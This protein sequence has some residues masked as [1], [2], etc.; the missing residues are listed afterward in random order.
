MPRIPFSDMKAEFKRVLLKKGTPEESAELSARLIAETSCDG[1]YSHG[2]NRFPRVVEYI[3]R[4][5]IDVSARPTLVESLGAFERWDGNLGL[6]NVCATLMMDRAIGL[7]RA[8]GIGCVA[9]AN[10]NH[11]LRGGTYGWQAANAGC[12]GLCWTNTQPNMPAWGAKDRRIGNNP[13]ILAVPRAGGAVVVD[14]AMAQFSYGQLE[15]TRN[16]GEALPVAGGYDGD[17]NLTTDPGA[18]LQS[19]RVLPIGFWKGSSLSLVLDLVATVLSGGRSTYR[20]GQLGSDEYQLSQV[21]IAIDA[22]RI[23]GDAFLA[24]AVDEVLADVKASERV[25][26]DVAIRYPAERELRVRQDNLEHGIPVDDAV[27]ARITAL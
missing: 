4:G 1:I 25:D 12:V 9:L 3:D 21:F 18:I 27:W 8:S 11:W 26:P 23:A 22:T 5:Y 15:A 16:R 24:S 19:W 7:A 10:T 13:L 17:G 2:V 14:M 6:G 20:V